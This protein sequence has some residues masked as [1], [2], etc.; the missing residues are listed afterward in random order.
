MPKKAIDPIVRFFQ[1][2]DKNGPIRNASRCWLWTGART[3]IPG[4]PASSGYGRFGLGGKNRH[5]HI[6]SWELFRGPTNGAWVLHRCDNPPCVNPDHLFLG[7]NTANQTD[8]LLKGRSRAAML[9]SATHC[10]RG[11][12][13]TPENT[14]HVKRSDDSSKW[15]RQCKTCGRM[16]GRVH[17]AK[18]RPRIRVR[19]PCVKRPPITHCKHG[20]EFTPENTILW[21][22]NDGSEKLWRQCRTC[23]RVRGR[24][25]AM[26]YRFR[27]R[28]N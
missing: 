22:L 1:Y 19:K 10:K 26:K 12:E 8:S 3:Y 11:H 17:D 5:A 24:E 6:V 18:R 23:Q 16:R 20:H 13:F 2:V 14:L 7:D 15:M 9:A 28:H 4:K 25:F 27:M 21:G